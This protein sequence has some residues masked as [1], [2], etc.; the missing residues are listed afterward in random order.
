M[1]LYGMT[2]TMENRTGTVLARMI[3]KTEIKRE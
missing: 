2:P 3:V 1:K